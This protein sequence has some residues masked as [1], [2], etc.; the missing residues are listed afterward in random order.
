MLEKLS[1]WML[2]IETEHGYELVPAEFSLAFH[3]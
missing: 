2:I 1:S 3:P